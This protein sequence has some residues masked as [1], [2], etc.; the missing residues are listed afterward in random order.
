MIVLD[1]NVV[2]EPMK[3][4]GDHAVKVWL[5][6]QSAETLYLTATSLFELLLVGIEIL[7]DGKRKE[8]LDGALSELMVRLFASRILLFDQQAAMAS[9][10]GPGAASSQ[11]RMVRLPQ[12]PSPMD[13]P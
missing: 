10:P 8:G 4:N 1:T 3:P 6:R 9:A 5:D 13:S 2:S 7:P 11:W 12:S